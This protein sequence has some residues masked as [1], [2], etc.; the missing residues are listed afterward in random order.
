MKLIEIAFISFSS[1][2]FAQ[3]EIISEKFENGIPETWEVK[4]NNP[5]RKWYAK[6][7]NNVPYVQMSAFG[8]RGKEGYKVKTE[9]HSP[10][11]DLS[12]KTCKIRFAFADA[13][14]NGQ[15]LQVYLVNEDFKPIRALKDENWKGLVNNSGRYD[16]AY[17]ATPWIELPKVNQPYRITFEY[18]SEIKDE[19]VTTTIQLNEVDVWCE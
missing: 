6:S 12:G 18:N 2:L 11:L 13:Y 9:L 16:N 10:L 14:Q 1:L 4:T 7:F 15:P 3:E 19:V 8:G 5:K 17:E